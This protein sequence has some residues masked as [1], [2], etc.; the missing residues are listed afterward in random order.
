MQVKV[1][2]IDNNEKLLK[3]I[4]QFFQNYDVEIMTFS[5]ISHF[6]KTFENI[7]PDLIIC[8]PVLTGMSPYFVVKWLKERDKNIPIIVYCENP[9]KDIILLARKYAVNAFMVYPFKKEELF[10]RIKKLLNVNLKIVSQE[11]VKRE[12]SQII[13]REKRKNEILLQIDKLPS[14]PTIIREI[15]NLINR[16]DS[17]ARD[18][19]EVIKKDQVITAKVLKIVNSPFY[20]LSRKFTTISESVAYIGL[21]A[22]RS[23]VYSASASNILK[24]SFLAYGYK[25]DL[26]WKHSFTTSFLSKKIGKLLKL[27]D[28]TCEELFVG[29]LLHDIGKIILGL[30]AKKENIF[31]NNNSEEN[32]VLNEEKKHFYFSHEEVGGLIADKWRLPELHKT[33]IISHHSPKDINTKVVFLANNMSKILLGIPCNEENL[34][35]SFKNMISFEENNYL[36]LKEEAE[37]LFEKLDREGIFS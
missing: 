36:L 19:E 15:E 23:V 27:G 32:N 20:S 2:I 26:L 28:K 18:F 13:E 22:L 29:G 3:S 33:I 10:L 21:D 6:Q 24:G 9:T 1:Y 11:T 30:M 5:K 31:F 16:E 7:K 34:V 8:N 12:A 25:R 17:D 35:L 4:E 37:E 14:F